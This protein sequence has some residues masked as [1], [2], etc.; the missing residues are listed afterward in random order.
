LQQDDQQTQQAAARTAIGK[1]GPALSQTEGDPTAGAAQGDVT[2]VEFSDVRC[3][4]CR[5]ML[6]VIADLLHADPKLRI[7]YKDIPILGPPSLLGAK[8]VLA[9]QRQDG[10]LKMRDAVMTGPAAITDDTLRASAQ[11][12]GLDWNRM[13]RDMSDPTIQTRLD[14]NIELA[15]QLGIEGTPSYVIGRKLL[16]GAASL[17]ELK[18]AVAAARAGQG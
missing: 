2:L 9:A 11:Q 4:Y 5:R 13:Q 14:A 15:R 17:S 1:A 3:P 16:P 7:V 12:A 10:Y 18:D 6:P 8:A